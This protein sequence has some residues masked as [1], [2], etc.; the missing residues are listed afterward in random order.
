MGQFIQIDSKDSQ[1]Q[2]I[3]PNPGEKPQPVFIQLVPGTVQDVVCSD[4]CPAYTEPSDINSIIAR[5]HIGGNTNYKSTER[6]RYYPLNRGIV[7]TPVKGDSVLLLDNMAGQNYYI[8]PL[9]STN[10]PNFNIDPLNITLNQPEG[11]TNTSIISKSSF[12][13]KFNIPLN[14][15]ISP[16]ARLSK[17]HNKML[18][19]PDGKRKGEDGSIAKEE[20]YGDMI[21]EGRFGNS[22]RIGSRSSNPLMIISNGRNAG[23]PLET[24]NDGSVIS[25]TSV[26]SLIDHFHDFALSSDLVDNNNRLIA[27]GNEDDETSV[28]DYNYGN[29]GEK[30]VISNQIFIRSDRIV[31][32]SV[33]NNIT[34][35]AFNNIDMG[36]GNNLTINTK[37]YT[38]IESSN[39]YLGKQAQELNEPLVLGTQLKE[40]LKEFLNILT[41]A[42]ALVQGAPV[43]LYDERGLSGQQ[44]MNHINGLIDK[45]DNPK[46][47][48]QYHY[49]EDNGQKSE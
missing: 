15:P 46:F 16:V 43:P 42:T 40:F 26:G 7:D 18:D 48:S 8:G 1:K 20:S 27:G 11:S 13:D 41:K 14:F 23:T 38:S 35:S 22:I 49:I 9:N 44:L 19:D 45:L 4:K 12:R 6:S 32:D 47:L 30:P 21:F 28:F 39:I 25:I 10:S 5:K 3:G 24:L 37:N 29:D 34:L 31:F 33:K 17:S 2:K 36:S